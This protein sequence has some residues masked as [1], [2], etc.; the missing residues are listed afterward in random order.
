M[1]IRKRIFYGVA[2]SVVVGICWFVFAVRH[3]P[4]FSIGFATRP[5]E[6][7]ICYKA[8]VTN[9]GFFACTLTGFR[10]EWKDSKGQ[11]QEANAFLGYGRQFKPGDVEVVS[12]LIPTNAQCVRVCVLYNGSSVLG[13]KI[14]S[15]CDKLSSSSIALR[16]PSF[17][18]WLGEKSQLS[19]VEFFSTWTPNKVTAT[20]QRPGESS[21][22]SDYSF[23]AQ[24][25]DRAVAKSTSQPDR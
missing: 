9:A 2:A 3:T 14:S 25:F 8:A 11:N 23:E 10:Y 21:D 13:R 19:E 1:H 7:R 24:V 16:F 20:N 17:A 6:T 4:Q 15:A 22:A 5:E 18:M 12:F